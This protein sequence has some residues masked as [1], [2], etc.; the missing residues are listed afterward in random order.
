VNAV[1][2]DTCV[3]DAGGA[4][5]PGDTF[6]AVQFGPLAQNQIRYFDLLVK[7]NNRFR[8]TVASSN[9][10]FLKRTAGGINPNERITYRMRIAATSLNSAITINS[11]PYTSSTFNPSAGSESRF[12]FN[13]TITGSAVGLIAGT[14]TDQITI[15]L[16]AL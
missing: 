13:V 11:F 10:G 2:V 7:N 6:Q 4:F 3:V 8:F 12:P 15:T 16:T 5:A 9:G 14:Y 1:Q